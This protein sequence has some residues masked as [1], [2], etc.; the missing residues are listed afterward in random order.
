MFPCHT[1][2]VHAAYVTLQ[3]ATAEVEALL[4]DSSFFG[5]GALPRDPAGQPDVA[6]A[7]GGCL[8]AL[9]NDVPRPRWVPTAAEPV[10]EAAAFRRCLRCLAISIRARLI[11]ST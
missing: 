10:S 9:R 8:A 4:W 1:G 5:P 2:W 6:A 11:L 7:L 3:D